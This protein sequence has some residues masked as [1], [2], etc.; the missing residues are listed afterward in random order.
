M[1]SREVIL[2]RMSQGV[3]LGFSRTLTMLLSTIAPRVD[4]AN[5]V[6]P[7]EL[8]I[9]PVEKQQHVGK[10]TNRKRNVQDVSI[11]VVN[12]CRNT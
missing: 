6:P 11:V 5:D 10:T 3:H 4:H 8:I 12:V 1:Q 2:H 7:F 9:S